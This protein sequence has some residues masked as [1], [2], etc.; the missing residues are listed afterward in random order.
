MSLVSK[1]K[2]KVLKER[3]KYLDKKAN[4]KG[5]FV[6]KINFRS[7]AATNKEMTMQ[8]KKLKATESF[9]IMIANVYSDTKGQSAERRFFEAVTTFKNSNRNSGLISDVR[10]GTEKEDSNG[11]DFILMTSIGDILIQIKSSVSG[12]KHFEMKY[13]YSIPVIII[14]DQVSDEMII[15]QM[16]NIF[17]VPNLTKNISQQLAFYI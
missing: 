5:L 8:D 16:L 11:I 17:E 10:K 2:K 12:K 14:N 6:E 4:K 1:V 7:I 15:T 3:Q 13:G 9:L